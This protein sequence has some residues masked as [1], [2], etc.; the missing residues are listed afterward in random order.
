MKVVC[1]IP[2][3]SLEDMVAL[4]AAIMKSGLAGCAGEPGTAKQTARRR[5]KTARR[6]ELCMAE[7]FLRVA[8][9]LPERLDGG[10]LQWLSFGRDFTPQF[11]NYPAFPGR[12]ELQPSTVRLSWPQAA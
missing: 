2:S 8:C 3:E 4:V 9:T 6:R 11:A 12:L 10:E 7:T 1:P 5:L